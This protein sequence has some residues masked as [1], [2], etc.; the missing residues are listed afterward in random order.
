MFRN[1]T[2]E[3]LSLQYCSI[4][5]LSFRSYFQDDY[6]N[7]ASNAT[8]L[9][10]NDIEMQ[11]IRP[12]VSNCCNV[13]DLST[14]ETKLDKLEERMEYIDQKFSD[15]INKITPMIKRLAADASGKA[16]QERDDKRR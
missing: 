11:T 7:L 5:V 3:C 16:K 6:V 15:M 8:T 1:K 2:S 10:A 9:D 4:N 12:K 14:L 13:P